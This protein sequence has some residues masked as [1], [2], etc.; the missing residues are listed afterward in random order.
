MNVITLVWYEGKCKN[1]YFDDKGYEF[2]SQY[3]LLLNLK[4]KFKTLDR[5]FKSNGEI[6]D[7]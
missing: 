4:R 7:K 6:D 1:Y 5:K 2:N 3:A